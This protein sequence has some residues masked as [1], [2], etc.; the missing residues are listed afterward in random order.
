MKFAPLLILIIAVSGCTPIRAV[1]GMTK[2][3]DHFLSSSSVPEVRYEPGAEQLAGHIESVVH[4]AIDRVQQRQGLFTRPVIVYATASVNSF[5]EYCTTP[6]AAACVLK[7]RLFMAPRLLKTP[8]RIAGILTHELSH[9]QLNQQLGSWKYQTRLPAWFHE[10]LAVYVADG[11]GAELISREQAIDAILSGRGFSPEQRGSVLFQRN[12]HHYNLEPHMFYRQASLFVIWLHEH[13][14]I[15]FE[16]MLLQVEQ[17]A[18]LY[19]AM[20]AAFGF[21][22]EQAWARFVASLRS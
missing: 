6:R 18:F 3:T 14:P 17:G 21:D 9:L 19:D 7:N 10:G 2:T 8:E 5:A 15:G 16:A 22:V 13:D 1:I 4:D 11:A 20:Q 12:A